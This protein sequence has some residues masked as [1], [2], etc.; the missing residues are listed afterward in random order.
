MLGHGYVENSQSKS[1]YTF[2]DCTLSSNSILLY[3]NKHIKC[4]T[5]LVQIYHYFSVYEH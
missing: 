5:V 4:I 2:I 3:F 1:L